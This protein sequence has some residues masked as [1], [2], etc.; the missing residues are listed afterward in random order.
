MKWQCRRFGYTLARVGHLPFIIKPPLF[1]F[2]FFKNCLLHRSTSSANLPRKPSPSSA[3]TLPQT[4]PQNPPRPLLQLFPKPPHKTLPAHTSPPPWKPMTDPLSSECWNPK[5]L[6]E[7]SYPILIFKLFPLSQIPLN[8]LFPTPLFFH[9]WIPQPVSVLRKTINP[10]S[11][12][13]SPSTPLS[14]LS[15]HSLR[16]RRTWRQMWGAR[17]EILEPTRRPEFCSRWCRWWESSMFL[18]FELLFFAR[19]VYVDC[20][21]FSAIGYWFEQLFCAMAAISVLSWIALH[22]HTTHVQSMSRKEATWNIDLNRQPTSEQNI[23]DS[24]KLN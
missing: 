9:C 15:T 19:L 4:S 10:K 21:L 2:S 12:F 22:L 24:I 11:F 18:P 17:R 14:P 5:P 1:S 7:K 3:P 20:L 8:Q 16:N 23:S 6:F 13:P